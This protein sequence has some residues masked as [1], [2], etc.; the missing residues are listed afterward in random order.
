[1][2]S[3]S[4][5]AS[6]DNP[7]A[8]KIFKKI[9]ETN[10]NLNKIYFIG[11]KFSKKDKL[12]FE[13]RTG[14]YFSAAN[15]NYLKKKT[16]K[17]I[18][19]FRSLQSFYNYKSKEKLREDFLVN[20]GLTKKIPQNILDLPKFG[21]INCHPGILPYFKGSCCPEWS[22]LLN[23]TVG[24]T[25]HLMNQDIDAG[26][27]YKIKK[28]EKKKYQNFNYQQ[29]RTLIFNEQ[30]SFLLKCITELVIKKKSILKFKKQKKENKFFKPINSEQLEKV[31]SLLK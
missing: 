5:I 13:E 23:K 15:L 30:I 8:I 7:L 17:K 1:M 12:I 9:E 28:I 19:K 25:L 27:I 26:P 31:K 29:F 10:L 20:A 21:I 2:R 14:A 24:L 6:P 4:F 18:C 16:L 3:F 22:I 11:K